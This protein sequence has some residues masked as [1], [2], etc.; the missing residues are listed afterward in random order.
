MTETS[1]SNGEDMMEVD[2][3]SPEQQSLLVKSS[4]EGTPMVEPQ[5]VFQESSSNKLVRSSQ[6]YIEKNGFKIL[7]PE[8]THR[9]EY[10]V[11]EESAV[12]LILQ[13]YDDDD[14]ITYL[15]KLTDGG[16]EMVSFLHFTDLQHK[17]QSAEA[18]SR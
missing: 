12:Q 9:W 1:T 16:E 2:K 14:G 5:F 8:V 11:Y 15:V 4:S 18:S 10:Q 13:E 3:D 7:V 6:H 17:L